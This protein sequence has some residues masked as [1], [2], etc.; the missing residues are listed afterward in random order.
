MTRAPAKASASRGERRPDST[1]DLAARRDAI[2]SATCDA[3][4]FGAIHKALATSA[5]AP[6]IGRVAAE[7]LEP[8]REAVKGYTKDRESHRSD[9]K[10][11]KTGTTLANV[12]VLLRRLLSSRKFLLTVRNKSDLLEGRM[13]LGKRLCAAV[14]ARARA[15]PR[16]ARVRVG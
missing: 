10:R 3:K 2:D 11:G 7:T 8:W 4:R 9:D 12:E 5:A 13:N 15:G 6:D 1:D 16:G 14:S